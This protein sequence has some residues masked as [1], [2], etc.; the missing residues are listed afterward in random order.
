MSHVNRQPL[1]MR[2]ASPAALAW[3]A[4]LQ[5][6]K[7]VGRQSSVDNVLCIGGDD[8]RRILAATQMSA[9]S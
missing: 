7:N 8:L 5:L 1:M 3:I 4:A 6:L 2:S 9:S